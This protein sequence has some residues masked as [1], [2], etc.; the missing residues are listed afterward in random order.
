MYI[1]YSNLR[2]GVQG[3]V[4]P[5]LVC[6]RGAFPLYCASAFDAHHRAPFRLAVLPSLVCRSQIHSLCYLRRWTWGP[7][8]WE[9]YK[10]SISISNLRY[11][12]PFDD[13]PHLNHLACQGHSPPQNEARICDGSKGLIHVTKPLGEL[14]PPRT[15]STPAW[16]LTYL[17][18]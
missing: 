5:A 9:A 16:S 11:E 17:Q 2:Q 7:L 18:M 8:I 4:G 1:L 13:A 12:Q 10:I 3:F 14:D 6:A 15:I